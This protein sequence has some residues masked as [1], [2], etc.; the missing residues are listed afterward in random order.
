MFLLCS[1]VL[2]LASY[3]TRTATLPWCWGPE[4]WDPH[5][6]CAR[7]KGLKCTSDMTCDICKD[8]SLAQWEAFMKKRSYSGRRKSSSSSSVLPTEPPALPPSTSASWEAGRPVPPPH[9]PTPPS[10]GRGHTE[11]SEGVSRIGSCGVSSPPSLCSVGRGGGCAVRVLAPA[12]ECD[13]AASS[14]TGFGVAG[15]SQSQESSVLACSAPPSVDSPA[16]AESDRRSHSHEVGDSVGGR[17]CSRFS[18]SSLSHSRES[19]EGC[20]H[21]R[22]RSGGSRSFLASRTLAPRP[23]RSLMDVSAL[24]RALHA[25][26]LP[27]CGLSGPGLGLWTA[28]RAVGFACAFGMAVCG[29]HECAQALLAV[30]GPGVIICCHM[31]PASGHR[32]GRFSSLT[33]RGHGI[34]VGCLGGVAEIIQRLLWPPGIAATLSRGW[35]LPLRW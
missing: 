13:L 18:L 28:T 31:G 26:P 9:P 10:K 23:I 7:Y 17:S 3:A 14:L 11:K 27:A 6:T 5:P 8:W 35:S 21:A 29:L 34:K 16:S 25:P 30:T 33:V 1:F 24:A 15:P 20:R 12:D 2:S 32:T 22:L 19:W 4:M